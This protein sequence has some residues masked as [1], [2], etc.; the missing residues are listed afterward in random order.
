MGGREGEPIITK[1]EVEVHDGSSGKEVADVI[2]GRSVQRFV[3]WRR[4]RSVKRTFCGYRVL[5]EEY[6]VQ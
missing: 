5:I 2:R 4:I 6:L 1:V 3:K